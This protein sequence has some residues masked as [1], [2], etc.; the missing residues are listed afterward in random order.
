MHAEPLGLCIALSCS[1]SLGKK[2][3]AI[4]GQGYF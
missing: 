2:A 1:W 4:R 3:Q